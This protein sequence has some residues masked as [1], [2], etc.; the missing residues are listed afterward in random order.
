MY[1]DNTYK[2]IN[3]TLLAITVKCILAI[4]EC[5]LLSHQPRK[6]SISALNINSEGFSFMCDIYGYNYSLID[7]GGLFANKLD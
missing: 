3:K 5:A 6:A 1:F 7:Y 4:R 2:R